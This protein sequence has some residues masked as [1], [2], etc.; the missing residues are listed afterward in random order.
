M[1]GSRSSRLYLLLI[2][3][4]IVLGGCSRNSG[5]DPQGAAGKVET[6][7]LQSPG[8]QNLVFHSEALDREMR[9]SIYLPTGYNVSKRYPVFYFIH[10]YGSRETDMWAGWNF[11]SMQTD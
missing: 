6:A 7:P 5:E 10:G 11:S 3:L 9:L 2:I 1:K 4:C 8:V